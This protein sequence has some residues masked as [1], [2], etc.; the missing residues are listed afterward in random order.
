MGHSVLSNCEARL[1][2]FGLR[3]MEGSSWSEASS[4][5]DGGL[6]FIFHMILYYIWFCYILQMMIWLNDTIF[7]FNEYKCTMPYAISGNSR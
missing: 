6:Y 2:W 3:F 7:L 5:T 4:N 1:I